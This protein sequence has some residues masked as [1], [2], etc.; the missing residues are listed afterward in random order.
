[1][2]RFNFPWNYY[3]NLLVFGNDP[4]INPGQIIIFKSKGQELKKEI[5]AFKQKL[6][7]AKLKNISFIRIVKEESDPG[8]NISHKAMGIEEKKYIEVELSIHGSK[9]THYVLLGKIKSNWRILL[10]LW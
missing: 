7:K 2:N 6:D 9:V 3:I 5:Q 8:Q 4:Q 10:I 1:M